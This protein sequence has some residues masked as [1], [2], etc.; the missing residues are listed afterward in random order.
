MCLLY[1]CSGVR[2]LQMHFDLS[3]VSIV[4]PYRDVS[5]ISK[6]SNPLLITSFKL[7]ENPGTAPSV[8]VEA[9]ADESQTSTSP[10][11]LRS[12]SSPWSSDKN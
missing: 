6:K 10:S 4:V 11:E 2:A 3:L 7:A 5:P 12:A 1:A 8:D 9:R